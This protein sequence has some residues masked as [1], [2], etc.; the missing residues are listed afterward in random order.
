[1]EQYLRSRKLLEL[2][3]TYEDKNI[4]ERF[5]ISQDKEKLQQELLDKHSNMK[6]KNIMKILKTK[7][8]VIN[9]PLEISIGKFVRFSY[10]EF[11]FKLKKKRYD[12]LKE[13]GSDQDILESAL[14]YESLLPGGQQWSIPLDVY[15]VFPKPLIE[16]FA[17]PFNSQAIML[18]EKFCSLRHEFG[19]LGNFFE[20]DFSKSSELVVINPPFVET[21]LLR[22]ANQAAEIPNFIFY[23][24]NWKDSEFYSV[25]DK[26]S[27]KKVLKRNQYNY[28]K[29]DKLI[30]AKFDSVVF[31][32]TNGTA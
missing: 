27:N 17:S 2:T 18:G 6:Y 30:I 11:T 28:E 9:H 4:L 32:R 23:G 22:A 16:A 15:R 21:I 29:N 10:G 12:K 8:L 14:Y 25:L 26:I 1:M 24:P 31:T 3:E 7:F 20:N 5:L 19:S 13:L